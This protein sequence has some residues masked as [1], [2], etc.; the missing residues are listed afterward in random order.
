MD[1]VT[2]AHHNLR[3]DTF[4]LCNDTIKPLGM[5]VLEVGHCSGRLQ[6]AHELPRVAPS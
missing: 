6:Y 3:P 5:L 4:E 2:S 1:D